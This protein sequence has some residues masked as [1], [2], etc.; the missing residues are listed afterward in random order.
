[1]LENIYWCGG[2]IMSIHEDVLNEFF[3]ELKDDDKFSNELVENLEKLLQKDK[4][5]SEDII[6]L[7]KR[8]P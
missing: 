8:G 3:E 6:N 5:N 2:V 4:V 1:M 7:I